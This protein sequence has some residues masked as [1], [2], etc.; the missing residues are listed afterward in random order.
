MTTITELLDASHNFVPE[1]EPRKE[2]LLIEDPEVPY[3]WFVKHWYV[4]CDVP[5]LS[6]PYFAQI[7]GRC[8]YRKA[9]W[10]AW[11]LGFDV[12]KKGGGRSD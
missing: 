12:S 6:F 1:G 5:E 2:A 3:Q 9:A 8:G 10:F 4:D 11:E 7:P